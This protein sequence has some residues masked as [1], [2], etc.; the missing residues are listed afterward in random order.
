MK[1]NHPTPNLTDKVAI[2]TGGTSGIGRATAYAFAR[3]GARVV[4]A[5]RREK[6]GN[7]VVGEINLAGGEAIFV[8]TD[9]TRE[10]DHI[11]LVERTLATFSRLDFAFNNAGLIRPAAPITEETTET[12][13]AIFD[14]NVRS[15]FYALKHQIPAM[16]RNGGG[17][18]V[19]NASVGGSVAFA[20]VSLYT[21]SKH[22]VIGLTKS[23]ALEFA[24][25]IVRVN[26][27]SP[28]GIQTPSFESFFG[29]GETEAKKAYAALHPLARVGTPEEVASAVVWLCSPGASFVTGHDLLVDGGFTA[30]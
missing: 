3:E 18:I 16:V 5:G 7:D 17:A 6:E 19:N 1:N 11:A 30:R 26:S 27:V 20:N 8:R 29:R 22:A 10:A 28:A 13:D 9:V 2:V 15:V 21:A 12:Y 23:A 25:K 14:A 4:V 24:E